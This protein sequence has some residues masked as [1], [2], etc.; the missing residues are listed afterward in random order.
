MRDVL[1]PFVII[2]GTIYGAYTKF[3]PENPDLMMVCTILSGI[4]AFIVYYVQTRKKRMLE[5][6]TEMFDS[7]TRKK[8]F[9]FKQN[10]QKPDE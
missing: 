6:S 9:F 10:N 1:L 5:E 8:F 7:E 3:M 2:F 4:L